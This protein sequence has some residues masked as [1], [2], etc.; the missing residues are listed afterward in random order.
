V[1]KFLGRYRHAGYSFSGPAAA[2]A[3]KSIDTTDMFV[4]LH[5]PHDFLKQLVDWGFSK[6]VFILGPSHHYYLDGCA[7]SKCTEY[8]TPVGNL[9]IDVESKSF[10]NLSSNKDVDEFWYINFKLSKNSRRQGNSNR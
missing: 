9:P 6:R 3:Y 4:T 8:E 10:L 5:I 2:W 1:G 7:L